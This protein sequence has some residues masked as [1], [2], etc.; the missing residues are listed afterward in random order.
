MVALID[1]IVNVVVEY[2]YDAWGNH[3]AEVADED[4][5]TLAE[6]NPFR[7]RG[8]YYDGYFLCCHAFVGMHFTGTCLH[9]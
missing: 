9:I 5:V 2:K 4:Y 1:S 6:I 8:Y 7:Y 3:E